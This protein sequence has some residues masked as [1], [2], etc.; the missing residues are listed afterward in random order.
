MV[1][2]V[3][4][5][6]GKLENPK[7]SYMR[8]TFMYVPLVVVELKGDFYYPVLDYYLNNYILKSLDTY[9]C[10]STKVRRCMLQKLE[11]IDVFHVVQFSCYIMDNRTK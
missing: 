1:Y 7:S 2:G 11:K 4:E 5:N 8:L 10:K 6:T 9:V 3:W